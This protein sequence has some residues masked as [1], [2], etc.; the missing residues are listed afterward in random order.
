MSRKVEGWLDLLWDSRNPAPFVLARIE[1]RD[2]QLETG[3]LVDSGSDI[4]ILMPS[5]AYEIL[6]SDLFNIDFAGADEQIFVSG[7]G[8]SGY[9]AVPFENSRML[10]E[11]EHQTVVEVGTRVWLAEPFPTQPSSG[12]NWALPSI[13]GRDAIRPGDFQLS[14]IES[15]ATLIRPDH[16]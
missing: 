5:D 4:T 1:H 14:Y 6:G 13:F 10:L 11:D 7:V 2:R 12:G 3:F 9:A 8:D 16:E 15:T